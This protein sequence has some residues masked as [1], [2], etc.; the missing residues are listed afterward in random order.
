[1]D[2]WRECVSCA[3]DEAGIS[4]TQQQIAIMADVTMGGHEN[5]DQAY[6]VPENPLID[7]N[8]KLHVLLKN[9]R[10]KEHCHT[11]NG[12]GRIIS[13]GPYHGSDSQCWKCFGEGKS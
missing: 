6:H 12:S 3:L 5:I 10:N 13:D 4:A 1:M 11:C 9:E 8:K 2:Y 7:E